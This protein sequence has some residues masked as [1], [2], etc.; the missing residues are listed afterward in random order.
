MLLKREQKLRGDVDVVDRK[1]IK[2]SRFYPGS[3]AG[4]FMWL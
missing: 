4:V 3:Y 1:K 2:T